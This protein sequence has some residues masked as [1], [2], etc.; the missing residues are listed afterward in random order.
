MGPGAYYAHMAEKHI[1]K[2]GKLI[3]V[4]FPQKFSDPGYPVVI[5]NR[6]FNISFSI[7]N[8]RPELYAP[9]YFAIPAYSFLNK[10]DGAVGF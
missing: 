7:R 8:H 9:E 6:L 5:F 10:K 1:D 4:G 3:Q 2:L